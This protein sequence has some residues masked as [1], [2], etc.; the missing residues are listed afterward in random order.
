MIKNCFIYII[1]I[2]IFII[3]L[4]NLK[5]LLWY[6]DIEEKFDLNDDYIDNLD[7][8]INVDLTTRMQELIDTLN[9]VGDD[10]LKVKVQ[11]LYDETKNLY[12]DINND[13]NTCENEYNGNL[14]NIIGNYDS[15]EGKNK[16]C[17]K[18][19]SDILDAKHNLSSC[20]DLCSNNNNC[21]SF[22]YDKDNN[23]CRLSTICHPES[24]TTF[25][26]NY[27]N[28]LYVKKNIT[29]SHSIKDF[30]LN[31]DEQCNNLC[32]NDIIGSTSLE[33]SVHGCAE[34]SKEQDDS[35]SFEYNFDNGE[36]TLRG[37]C[38]TGMHLENSNKFNCDK[39]QIKNGDI[40]QSIDYD[41]DRNAFT[42]K[43]VLDT[44]SMYELKKKCN[45][46]CLNN[47]DCNGFTYEF[48][49]G[50]NNCT[51]YKDFEI[52]KNISKKF[53]NICEK[54]KNLIKKNLYTKKTPSTTAPDYDSECQALCENS[55]N[56]NVPYIKFY[57]NLDDENYSYITF[58]DMYNIKE[59]EN[60]NLMDYKFI[61]IK[62]GY[63]V[64]FQNNEEYVSVERTYQNPDEYNVG[65]DKLKQ[66]IDDNDDDPWR[67]KIN[68]IRILKLQNDCRGKMSNCE[69]DYNTR[70]YKKTFNLFYGDD[71]DKQYCYK[72]AQEQ[73]GTAAA[74][75]YQPLL[76]SQ[77][78][79]NDING[80]GEWSNCTADEDGIYKKTWIE[81]RPPN[82]SG[83]STDRY[84]NNIYTD[85]VSGSGSGVGINNDNI[86]VKCNPNYNGSGNGVFLTDGSYFELGSNGVNKFYNSASNTFTT[87]S[88]VNGITTG[89]TI[90]PSGQPIRIRDIDNNEDVTCHPND[91][92]TIDDEPHSYEEATT[93]PDCD[94]TLEKDDYPESCILPSS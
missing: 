16:K 64:I 67:A 83:N 88:E 59:I 17:L 18:S 36:C 32:H 56:D 31:Q 87:G 47:P 74:R 2:F 29:G 13:K 42:S 69:Y 78:C 93:F 62:M 53:I 21:M 72:L 89:T 60:F 71:D 37:E 20:A 12:D 81:I 65:I 3:I 30:T 46:L 57:K 35:I 41:I 34:K 85:E 79:T 70:Q 1:L 5:N 80:R 84:G 11:N 40:L 61:E 10:S 50:E 48:T 9:N 55:V 39:G 66:N 14:L 52:E 86:T 23:D 38:M 75:V 19:I 91:F 43:N 73:L 92:C 27:N 6:K 68:V 51:L 94:P 7:E 8:K 49:E 77:V 15:E 63:K 28:T 33:S 76:T 26:Q 90:L 24:D 25:T 22:S 54:P 82:G 58:T 45:T 4:I 44:R